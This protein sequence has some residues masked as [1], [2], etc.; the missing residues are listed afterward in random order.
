[1]YYYRRK[2]N[3]WKWVIIVIIIIALGALIYWFYANYFSR[4]NIDQPD[5][6]VEP[7]INRDLQEKLLVSLGFSQGDVLMS[8]DGQAYES[9]VKDKILH[10]GDKIKTGSDSLAVLNLENGSII[11]LG[12][13]TE[14]SLNSLLTDN[15]MIDQIKGRSYYN[16][17][18]VDN[19]QIKSLDLIVKNLSNKFELITNSE[20]QFVAALNFTGQPIVEVYD[21]QGLLLA[22]R[23]ADQQKALIDFNKSIS[24]RL[25]IQEFNPDNLTGEE[26]Y[27][28][29]FDLDEN[30]GQPIESEDIEQEDEEPAFS[31]T[32]QSLE[33]AADL[34]QS[35]V[36]LSWSIYHAADFKNYKI[37]RSKNDN[38][39][40]YPDNTEIKSSLS[41]GLNS[42]LDQ[43]IDSGESY[44]YRVCVIKT[45]DKVV[46]GNVVNMQVPADEEEQ[47]EETQEDTQ[48]DTTP[49]TAPNLSAAISIGGVSLTWEQNNENDFKQYIVLRSIGKTNPNY[50]TD[51]FSTTNNPQLV[52]SNVN[53]TSVGSYYYQVCSVDQADNYACSNIIAVENGQ[54]K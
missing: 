8:I 4:I 49:P 54:I 45:N 53:I 52:D 11:R 23:L 10:Q 18:E 21:Q 38:N 47:E 43:S 46:C 33:L 17:Q 1:M 39:L 24:N 5:D 20:A 19:F 50:L 15:I 6:Q 41:R 26:W 29:N 30:I 25:Q 42:Y 13:N 3:P 40:K 12:Q 2:T 34:K 14:I 44:Y 9:A 31:V 7:P 36:F 51:Q 27:Q 37:V 16:L 35:G 48:E 22:R 28:W 32:D